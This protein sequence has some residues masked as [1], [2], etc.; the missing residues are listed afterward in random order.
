MQQQAPLPC[1]CLRLMKTISLQ[2]MLALGHP[3]T[4]VRPLQLW[5]IWKL[6]LVIS[7]R[8]FHC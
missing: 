7:L 6:P 4:L 3:V 5:I 1:L 8:Q 2:V